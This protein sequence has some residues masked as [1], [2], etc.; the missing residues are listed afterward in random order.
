VHVVRR[1]ETLRSIARDRLGN[2]H[3]ADE[4]IELNRD[5]LANPDQLT[6]GQRLV[7]PLDAGIARPGS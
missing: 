2:V 4:I 1:Y 3:R 5:R 6:P 7:L